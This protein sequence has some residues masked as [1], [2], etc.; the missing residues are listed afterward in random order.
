MGGPMDAGGRPAE[1]HAQPEALRALADRVR[2]A[3]ASRTRLR[4]V[5]G[6]TKRFVAIDPAVQG[7][8]DAAAEPL[9][10]RGYAGIVSYE[11]SELVM[12]VRAGTPLAEVEAALAG[13][14]QCLPF[15]P[16]RFGASGAV[17]GTVG[18]MVAAGLAGPARGA[19]GNV[20][21]HVLGVMLLDGRGRL[22][23]F[24]G[25]VIKNVAGYD[26]SR[27]VAG[28]WGAL[29]LAC[30]VSIKVMPVMPAERTLRFEMEQPVAIEA[31]NHWAGQPL[32]LNASVWWRGTLCVRL[33]G[34]VAAVEAATA[35]LG[36]DVIPPALAAAFWS[37]LRDQR[38]EFFEEARGHL[39][40]DPTLALW[41]LSL[42]A[43][44]PA[45]PVG[46]DPLIEWGGAQRWVLA[47]DTQGPALMAAAQ[48]AGGAA[49]PFRRGTF[50]GG[51]DALEKVFNAAEAQ[52]RRDP[53]AVIQRRLKEAFDPHDVFVAGAPVARELAPTLTAF[54]APRGGRQAASERPGAA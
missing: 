28:S 33:R 50:P 21:D 36:G 1:L 46:T 26:V 24:G 42:P 19:V 30:E 13:C 47:P 8:R 4:I 15:E 12:T 10:T 41:R 31:M 9:S 2:D 53:L 6:D 38:D 40:A 16:P 14:G 29:G 23:R 22:M 35:R 17:D 45:L 39:D 49:R 25:E 43:T 18:G 11:P 20:R 5:G 37:G 54:A 48:A 52:P 3:A 32:P 51:A 34:A 7:P 27:L 44:A